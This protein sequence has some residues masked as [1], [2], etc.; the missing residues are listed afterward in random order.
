MKT[1]LKYRKHLAGLF[2][3]FVILL[4][5]WYEI[6]SSMR[7]DVFTIIFVTIK[8]L[9]AA[10][11]AGCLGFLIGYILDNPRVKRKNKESL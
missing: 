2:A 3:S 4:M 6:F 9:P 11:L 1:D 7:I 10:F 8:V 5:L